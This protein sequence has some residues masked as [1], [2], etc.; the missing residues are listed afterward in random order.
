MTLD[1]ML[2][3]LSRDPEADYDLAEVSLLLAKDEYPHLDVGGY[4]DHLRNL[5]RDARAHVG[6][7]TVEQVQ[8]LCRYLFH[9]I[10]LHG[11]TKNYYDPR[12]SY[13][14]D[15]LDRLKGIP[16]TL[17]AVMIA[18]GRRLGL[19]L[20]GLGLPGH[21]AV[22]CVGTSPLVIVDP[23]HGGRLLTI[24]QCRAL[25][26]RVTG[27]ELPISPHDLLPMPPALILRRM[28]NNLRVIYLKKKDWRRAG[29]VL[30]RMHQ[31]DPTDVQIRR[32]LG[33]CFIHE[34]QPGKAIDH[35]ESYLSAAKEAED[36]IDVTNL[37][38]AARR[39]V[40]RWN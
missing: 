36:I 39:D 15:V 9:E 19:P 5:A 31:L 35:L 28:L 17:S 18:V 26:A 25:V 20:A 33:I 29:R 2:V 4:L 34:K 27:M 30:G 38:H 1:E 14:S 40:G 7:D 10:G 6:G 3:H 23:F 16:I 22:Q 13:L 24:E 21:F 37:F 8:G 32:D 11:N 12:N